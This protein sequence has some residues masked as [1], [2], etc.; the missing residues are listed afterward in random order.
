VRGAHRSDADFAE[1]VRLIDAGTIYVDPVIAGTMPM[2]RIREAL[3]VAA[4]RTR[5]VKAQLTFA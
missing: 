2:E 5:S 3:D 1:A 4:D